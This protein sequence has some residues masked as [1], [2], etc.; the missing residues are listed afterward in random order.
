ENGVSQFPNLEGRFPQVSGLSFSF[1]PEKEPN[2]RINP[3]DIKIKGQP[4]D[5]DKEYKL[6]TKSFM[7]DGRDGYEVLK[8][9]RVLINEDECSPFPLCIQQY[10]EQNKGQIFAPKLENRII[11]LKEKEVTNGLN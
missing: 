8:K 5:L 10:F 11:N 7:A 9:C 1:D 3:H 2:K 4:L 6:A